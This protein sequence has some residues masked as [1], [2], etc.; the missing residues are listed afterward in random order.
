MKEIISA[1]CLD[2]VPSLHWQGK[3]QLQ[4]FCSTRISVKYKNEEWNIFITILFEI[5]IISSLL[6]MSLYLQMTKW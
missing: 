4:K 6:F 2:K 5:S 1:V 3:N